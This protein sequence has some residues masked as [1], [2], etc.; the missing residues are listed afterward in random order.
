VPRV[1]TSTATDTANQPV[2][3]TQYMYNA[4]FTLIDRVQYDGNGNSAADRR[5][6]F[7][8][9]DTSTPLPTVTRTE[10]DTSGQ[11]M[12]TTRYEYDYSGGR[13]S[14]VTQSEYD[15]DGSG[16]VATEFEYQ[17]TYDATTNLVT[18]VTD[19]L[20]NTL[21][22]QY[23]SL[24]RP[25]REYTDPTGPNQTPIDTRYFYDA[26]FNQVTE[27]TDAV[28]GRVTRYTY[29]TD[30]QTQQRL[31]TS[32]LAV[33]EPASLLLLAAGALGLARLRRRR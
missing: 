7:Q 21:R 16:P 3:N 28:G 31:L 6:R 8:Y 2:S 13:L 18:Q 9:D 1:E 32:A 33:P 22:Y 27:I 26:Q 24:D 29:D 17:Y 14:M 25:I 12:H 15:G 23:D 4:T 19:N 10:Y 11:P 30:P 20:G 5:E